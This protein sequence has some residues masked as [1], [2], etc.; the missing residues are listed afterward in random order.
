MLKLIV[1]WVFQLSIWTSLQRTFS[2]FSSAYM[3]GCQL[4]FAR[5]LCCA[6]IFAIYFF[7]VIG[8]MWANVNYLFILPCVFPVC[9]RL[10]ITD[11]VLGSILYFC[12]L[13]AK[14]RINFGQISVYHTLCLP[15]ILH[16]HYWAYSWLC[17]F[18]ILD[19]RKGPT[20]DGL[21]GLVSYRVPLAPRQSIL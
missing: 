19:S 18:A 17:L 13:P 2:L 15:C 8:K 6:F 9:Y 3:Y 7:F 14:F 4:C 20:E 10:D 1:P 12:F 5:V 11:P 21:F 16:V